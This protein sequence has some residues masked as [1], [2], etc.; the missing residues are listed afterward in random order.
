M[1]RFRNRWTVLVVGLL[2][3]FALVAAAC[4]DDDSP[5]AETSNDP[6]VSGLD[7]G[8]V[9]PGGGMIAPNTF[10]EYAGRRYQLVNMVQADFLDRTEFTEAGVATDIDIDADGPVTVYTR[11][12]DETG[13]W[14]YAESVDGETGTPG[15]WFHWELEG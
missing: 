1:Q 14:T 4:G 15:L 9:S 5:P 10:L 13:V 6:A 12:G 2:A 11:A 3:A 8:S 7:G